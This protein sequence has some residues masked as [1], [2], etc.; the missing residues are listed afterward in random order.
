MIKLKSKQEI[1]I[2]REN[3]RILSEIT[4]ELKLRVKEGISTGSLNHLAEKLMERYKVKPAFKG[5]RG[6]PASICT[7][8][9]DEVVHGIP[10][11]ERVLKEG[12]LLSI[13]LGIKYRGF[14]AD[15]ARSFPVGKV[16]NEIEKISS[17]TQT[18][19]EKGIEACRAGSR[20]SDISHAIGSYVKSAG[21]YVVREFVGHG[22][23]RNLHE[24]PQVPNYGPPSE[25]ALLRSGLVLALEPM[26]KQSPQEVKIL[27][28]GWTVVTPDG[29]PSTHVEDM[30]LITNGRCEVLTRGGVK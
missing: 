8:I 22:I 14:Y 25:G 3:C 13:D 7:S 2:I 30:V 20:V 15:L 28:D 19:L 18:S 4:A 9:N 21:F 10:N 12:D 27:D 26:V 6:F 16:S 1:K 23:G 29:K 5:Y 11:S 24:D 17:V